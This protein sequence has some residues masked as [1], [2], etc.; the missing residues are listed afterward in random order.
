[1]LIMLMVMPLIP[2]KIQMRGGRLVCRTLVESVGK[3]RF[4]DYVTVNNDA[5][6]VC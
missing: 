6:I 3:F 4:F 2:W 1:M 5:W